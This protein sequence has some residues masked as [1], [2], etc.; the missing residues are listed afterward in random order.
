MVEEDKSLQMLSF[1]NLDLATPTVSLHPTLQTCYSIPPSSF[2]ID[3][4]L[5]L[6]MLVWVYFKIPT[7]F[8]SHWCLYRWLY[9]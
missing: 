7:L 3:L 1:V 2:A 8:Y 6:R 4:L 5:D 9:F